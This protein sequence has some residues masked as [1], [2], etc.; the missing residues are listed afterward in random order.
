MKIVVICKHTYFNSIKVRL[1]LFCVK[2]LCQVTPFQFHKGTI[3]T[4]NFLA[5]LMLLKLNFN[6][7]KVRLEPVQL[8][9]LSHV[10]PCYFNSIKVRLERTCGALG[11]PSYV[12]FNSIK[13]RLEQ[14]RRQEGANMQVFQFHKGTIRTFKKLITIKKQTISIP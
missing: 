14:N 11:A 9:Q 3:R 2:R 8:F 7:I 1:E 5:M 13:V 4:L 10:C 12:Y 6:S